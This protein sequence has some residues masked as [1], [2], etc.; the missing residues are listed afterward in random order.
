MKLAAYIL[1]LALSHLAGP[2]LAEAPEVTEIQ[3][4]R[5]RV[6]QLEECELKLVRLGYHRDAEGR[7]WR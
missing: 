5:Q 2:G 1:I 6:K 3:A 4:L 7:W